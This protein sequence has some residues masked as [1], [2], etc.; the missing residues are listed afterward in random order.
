MAFYMFTPLWY[1]FAKAVTVVRTCYN[2][3]RKQ[4][5]SIDEH[6]LLESKGQA[7]LWQTPESICFLKMFIKHSYFHFKNT[8]K[9]TFILLRK[10]FFPHST[11]FFFPKSQ[12]NADY[13]ILNFFPDC[14]HTRCYS[15]EH[16]SLTEQLNF[17]W[18]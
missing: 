9:L 8:A 14:L 10:E 13:K 2:C 1:I 11:I 3:Q 17:I 12:M 5:V 18:K 6:R 4:T 15:A 16:V 7:K